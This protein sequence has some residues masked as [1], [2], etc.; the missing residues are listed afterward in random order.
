[1]GDFV[2]DTDGDVDGATDGDAHGAGDGEDDGADVGCSV[3]RV[4]DAEGSA[5]VPVVTEHASTVSV[6][7]VASESGVDSPDGQLKQL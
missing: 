1:M 5:V 6:W 7:H 3:A 4:G 2:G